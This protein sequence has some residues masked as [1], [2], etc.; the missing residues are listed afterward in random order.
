MEQYPR[1]TFRLDKSL[2][3]RINQLSLARHRTRGQ[4]CRESVAMYHKVHNP[5]ISTKQVA[6]EDATKVA[7]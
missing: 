6:N 7:P 4:I 3:T 5:V 1:F 2:L